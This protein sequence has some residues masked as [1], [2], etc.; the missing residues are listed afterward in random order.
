[1]RGAA[2]FFTK[3]DLAVAYVQFRIR[4][5]DQH[6]KSF[7]VPG[8]QYEFCVGAFGLHGMSS[9]LMCYMHNII[10]RPRLGRSGAACGRG[11][12]I[13]PAHAGALHG[14]LLR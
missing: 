7:R 3:I 12:I 9:V 8:G 10:G 5:E 6:K 1:M 14:S 13:D 4:E 2:R 11:R